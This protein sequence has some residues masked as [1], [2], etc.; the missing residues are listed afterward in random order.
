MNRFD[1]AIIGGGATGCALALGLQQHTQYRVA[2]IDAGEAP[3]ITDRK[4]AFDQRTLALSAS[5][6]DILSKLGC[7][8]DSIA[9]TPI[10]HIH[11]SDK[12]HLGQTVL[13]A[14]EGGVLAFGRVVS[15]AALGSCLYQ[16]LD[17]STD[18]LLYLPKTRVEKIIQQQDTNN[19]QLS[20]GEVI[21]CKL[22]VL[23]DGGRSDAA[24]QLGFER[25]QHDY[26]QSAI[27]LNIQTSEPHNNWAYER[28]T[29]TGPIA[30]LPLSANEYGVVWSVS[31]AQAEVYRD[32]PERYLIRELQQRFGYRCGVIL[33]ASE[34]ASYPLS[35]RR[36]QQVVKHR[37]VAVGNAAQTLHPI[38]GQGVN[39]G[40]R[41]VQGLITCLRDN[42]ID[43]G[44]FSALQLYQQRQ[45]QDKDLTVSLTD[46]LVRVFANSS[47]VFQLVRNMGLTAM[48]ILPQAKQ[49]FAQTAMGMRDDR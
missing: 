25:V 31:S 40:F 26:Q 1:I 41:D 7:S 27:T 32:A 4:L 45:E 17:L 15:L 12:G 29:D 30:L 42:L 35:L 44:E 43:C 8:L 13:H 18:T 38:A 36:L 6:I 5:S 11:V 20:C 49:A 19:L 16:Q 10:E 24:T 47:P 2:M 37:A 28:F 21:E 48:N 33:Q 23:A 34:Y 22:V 39:L 3:Q 9:T 14:H 46:N